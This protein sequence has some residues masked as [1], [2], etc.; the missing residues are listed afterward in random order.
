MITMRLVGVAF[1][2]SLLAAGASEG[3][4]ARSASGAPQQV[5]TTDPRWSPWLGCWRL[6][7][8]NVQPGTG[9]LEQRLSD[10]ALS[11]RR[12]SRSSGDARV[13]VAPASQPS[14][15]T[16]TT[17]VGSDTAI[18]ETIF[19]DGAEHP[20]VEPDCK[21]WQRTAWSISGERLFSSAEIACNNQ[22][23]RKVSGLGLMAT[24]PTWIDIQLIEL[25]GRQSVRVRRY[26]QVDRSAARPSSGPPTG[27][28]HLAL[29]DIKELS[30]KLPPAVVQ[31]ALVELKAG[32]TLTSR[33]LIELDDAGVP[34]SVIDLLVA[35]SY[36][37]KFVVER[38]T[39]GGAST[40]WDFSPYATDPFFWQSYYSPYGYQGWGYYD[41][42]Y[43]PGG[44]VIVGSEPSRPGTI[45]PS[46]EGRVVDGRGY[47]RVRR[48]DPQPASDGSGSG[49]SS[50]TAR[51]TSSGPSS[52]GTASP[53]GY[54][55]SGGGGGGRTAQPRP[56]GDE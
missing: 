50:S 10:T 4:E 22:A 52:G 5:S 28:S 25:G 29:A 39:S 8:E 3:Q 35:L 20:I 36:P 1:T 34:D 33:Q 40:S 53:G 16:L 19:A 2:L 45:T 41:P 37:A 42:F 24:G 51:G 46:G 38:Q 18:E 9:V 44:W 32:R 43:Y 23:L 49:E 6:L 15:V 26:E 12:P 14:G 54:S 7:D 21:G 17:M 30:A 11:R 13:C 27:N 55:G 47:T 31:A 48:N 56:P